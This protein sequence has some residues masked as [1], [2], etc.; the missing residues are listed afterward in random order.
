MQPTFLSYY[1]FEGSSGCFSPVAKL[2]WFF[3]TPWTVACHTPLSFTISWSLLKFMSVESVML[4]NHFFLCHSLL[5]CLQS[6]LRSGYFPIR[7]LFTSIFSISPANEYS[8]LIS[9]RIYW[10]DLLAVQGTLKSLLQNHNSKAS[11]LQC[12]LFFVETLGEGNCNLL[13]YSCLGN[14]MHRG[15]CWAT[16]HGVTKK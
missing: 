4:S 15:A 16:V 2:C 3:V 14:P 10:F 9:F 5:L 11:I 13:Q 8:G 1:I 6:F 12:L 7:Q